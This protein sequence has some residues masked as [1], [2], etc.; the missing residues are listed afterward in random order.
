[1]RFRR[2]SGATPSASLPFFQTIGGRRLR[3]QIAIVA[4]SLVV[5]Y[6]IT[7]FWLFPAPLFSHEHA[8]PRVLD[9][10]VTEARQKLEAQGLR[11][12]LED[13]QTDP[14]APR[15]AVVWQDPPPGTVVEPNSIVSL[16]LSDGPPD[17]AVPDVAGFPRALAERVLKAA[18]LATGRVDTLPSGSDSGIVVQ[19]RP[20]SGVGRPAGTTIDL[21]VSSGRAA[22]AVPDLVGASLAEARDQLK[23]A[24]LVMGLVS[25]RPASGRPEG[26]VLQQRPVPGTRAGRGTRVDLIV[27][28]KES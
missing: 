4:A 1:M 14:T 13:P 8:V 5:G 28:G 15:N 18:G 3:W 17:V 23:A 10:G 20:G 11:F 24:G 21:V 26:T 22:L 25:T 6:L 2:P 7:V 12:R 9:L 16:T 27:A 19:S